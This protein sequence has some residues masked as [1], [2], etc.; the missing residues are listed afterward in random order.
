VSQQIPMGWYALPT[1]GEPRWWDGLSWTAHR[2]R[3]GKPGADRYAAEPAGVGWVLGGLLI[4]I[5]LMN[6]LTAMEN[7][8]NLLLAVLLLL[9]GALF[10]I[11]AGRDAAR[12]KLPAPTTAPVLDDALRPLPGEAEAEGA[13]WYPVSGKT[14]HRWWTGA[15]WADYVSERGRVRP[16]HVGPRAYLSAMIIGAV[17]AA[18]ALVVVVVGVVLTVGGDDGAPMLTALGVFLLFL[19]GVIIVSV[20]MRRYALIQP[21]AAPPLK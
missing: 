9:L 2:V 13:G 21:K 8:V 7:P 6:L 15:R 3:N 18:L 20:W 14:I 4:L 16:T 1:S 12:R 11:G 17:I 5:G 19:A 10:M